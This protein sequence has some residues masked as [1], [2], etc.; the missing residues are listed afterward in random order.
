VYDAWLNPDTLLLW[1]APGGIQIDRAQVDRSVGGHYR[2][3]HTAGGSNAGG[4]ECE[5]TELVPDR[6]IVFRWGFVGPVRTDGPVYDSLLTIHLEEVSKG[7]TRLTLVHEQLDEL[8]AALPHV[9]E[10]VAGG[11]ESVLTKLAAMFTNQQRS[12][13]A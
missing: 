10:Q 1:L 2:I 5:I 11:W 8:S 6:R 4:F 7:M 13:N 9:A 12:Q 3:W